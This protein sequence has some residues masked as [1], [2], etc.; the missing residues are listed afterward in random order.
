MNSKTAA[1]NST[2]S[3]DYFHQLKALVIWL[4]V[5]FAAA[6]VG[7]L[8]PP[9]HWYAELNRPTFAPPN[10][11]FG[12]VWTILYVC[13]AISAW[14]VWREAALRQA[15]VAFA[16]F[17]GQLLLNAAWSILFFGLHSPAAAL[18]DLLLLWLGI[19][20]T[21]FAFG[22]YSGT[23]SILLVPYLAWVTFAGFLNYG[24][25]RLN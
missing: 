11:V 15:P 24:F 17:G 8:F 20:A 21:I 12:P 22:R 10:W 9:D 23:A 13:M 7:S 25:W 18:A 3:V 2:S 6:G 16:L 5:C 19:V 1:S 14:L 4:L